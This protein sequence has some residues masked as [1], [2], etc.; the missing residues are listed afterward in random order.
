ME[1]RLAL[2]SYSVKQAPF[3]ILELLPRTLSPGQS[4]YRKE[5]RLIFLSLLSRRLLDPV[6]SITRSSRVRKCNFSSPIAP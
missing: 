1:V 6:R 5:E 3:P 2:S 4:F